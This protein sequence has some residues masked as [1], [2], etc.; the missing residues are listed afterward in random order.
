[1]LLMGVDSI[2]FTGDDVSESLTGEYWMLLS[3][4]L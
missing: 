1:M 4:E 3:F 2:S